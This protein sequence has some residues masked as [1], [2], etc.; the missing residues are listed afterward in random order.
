MGV[1]GRKMPFTPIS[2][3]LGMSTS[4]MMPPTTTSTSSSPCV[5]QQLHDPRTDVIVRARQDGQADDVGVFLEG[6][7]DNLLGRLPQA[8]VDDFHARVTK[9]ARDDL[10]AAVVPVETRLGDDDSNL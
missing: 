6:R 10:G 4:G 8:G 2:R 9:G 5:A 3:S 7:R 1:P